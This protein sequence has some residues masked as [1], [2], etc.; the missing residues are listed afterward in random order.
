MRCRILV[1]AG[2][3]ACMTGLVARPVRS[4]TPQ[5]GEIMKRAQQVREL[6]ITEAD[7]IKIGAGVSEKVR[8]RYG[9]VQNAAIH[10]YVSLVGGVLVAHSKRPG[11]PWKFVVLDTDGVNAFAAPGGYIH[12]TRGALALMGSEAE[13]ADVLAHEIVHVTGKHTVKAI[14]KS[15]AAQMGA[16]ETLQN[17][18]V[19][20]RIV[21][22]TT[23]MV[24]AGFGRGEEL[25]SD[26]EGIRLASAVGYNPAGLSAFLT[27]LTERNK[28]ATEKQGLFASH[29][30][31][32]ERLDKLAAQ[33]RREKLGG[34]A[35]LED[36]YAKNVTYKPKAQTEIAAVAPGSAGLA[37]GSKKPAEEEKKEDA[38][39]K[40]GFGIG[41]LLKPTGSEKKSA[42]VTGSGASRGV[43]TERGAKGGAV[44]T[45]VAVTI[46]Q[47]DL[48]EF[49]RQGHLE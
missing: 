42:E 39:K 44:P 15:K 46:T 49:R 23:E 40:K 7:E 30:E 24:L 33:V 18:Q 37:G 19:F 43:D 10:R 17:A 36:R 11:L 5:L 28:S 31:M 45:L 29:P 2:L 21:D 34:A 9:V 32:K 8:V 1:V 13:L 12:I 41:S 20:S 3:A 47:T 26:E 6:T 48:D 14:Q 25:A 35:T 16:Q 27:R 38:P 4:G 22:A